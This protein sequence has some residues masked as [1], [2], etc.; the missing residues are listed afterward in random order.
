MIVVRSCFYPLILIVVLV[1]S[2]CNKTYPTGRF[3]DDLNFLKQY[4]NPIVL[5]DGDRQIIVSPNFQGRVFSST[6]KGINGTSY[7]WFNKRIMASDSA[8][9]NMSKVGG[10]SRIW[11]GPDQGENNVFAEIHP[12]T[13]KEVRKAPK[14]LD[15]LPFKVLEKTNTSIVLGEK[16]HIKNV[17]GFDFYVDVVRDIALI[18]RNQIIER[19]KIDLNQVDYVAFKAKTTMTNIGEVNWSKNQGL[20]S[21]WELGCMQPTPQTTVV[22]PLRGKA[23]DATVY[24]TPVDSTRLNIKNNI[25]FYKADANYLN[26]IG[27]LPEHTMPYFGSYSPE[28]DLL[29]IVRFRFAGEQDYVNAHP[30]NPEPF[31]GDVINVFN[32]GTWG[33]IGPFG[34]FYELET[35]SP[36]KTLKVGESLSHVHETYHFEGTKDVLN[37]I[38]IQVLGVDLTTIDN[39]LP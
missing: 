17:K 8:K 1:S 4:A 39:A 21:L 38:A 13:K 22:I 2:S 37:A 6:S 18:K 12:D 15:E 9:Q 29:T 25:L 31:R 5:A 28:L 36:A 16:M 14:D 26:K 11:F 34:P 19:L 24:F 32:D 27:T 30:E 7:G 3:G 35:S 23:T 10:A 20:I 33:D